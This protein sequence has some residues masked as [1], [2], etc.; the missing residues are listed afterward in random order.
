MKYSTYLLF[1]LA[2]AASLVS[3]DSFS[4]TSDSIHVNSLLFARQFKTDTVSAKYTKELIE[5]FKTINVLSGT[6]RFSG[7]GFPDVASV[8]FRKGA[9]NSMGS[10]FDRC[11]LGSRITFENC[12]LIKKDGTIAGP[13]NKSIFIQ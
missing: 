5:K 4:Q 10:F 13:I 11:R 8:P 7:T 9:S 6:V 12:L 3:Q 1:S 2:L